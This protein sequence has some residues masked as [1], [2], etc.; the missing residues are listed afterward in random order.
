MR[1][2]DRRITRKLQGQIPWDP[3][4]GRLVRTLSG[5]DSWTYQLEAAVVSCTRPEQDGREGL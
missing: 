4:R 2:R 5:H 3:G 1:D